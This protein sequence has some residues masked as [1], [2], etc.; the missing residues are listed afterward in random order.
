MQGPVCFQPYLVSLAALM[1]AMMG[2][3]I[4]LAA[5]LAAMKLAATSGRIRSFGQVRQKKSCFQVGFSW[6]VFGK[7]DA[8]DPSGWKVQNDGS[9]SHRVLC[10]CVPLHRQRGYYHCRS[11]CIIKCLPVP[12]SLDDKHSRQQ[13]PEASVAAA[14]K[15]TPRLQLFL[16]KDQETI[17]LVVEP[18]MKLRH[19]VAYVSEDQYLATIGGRLLGLDKTVAELGLLSGGTLQVV[20]RLRVW[21]LVWQRR[22]WSSPHASGKHEAGAPC[23][24]G[25]SRRVRPSWRPL[26][27]DTKLHKKETLECGGGA[28][29][30]LWFVVCGLWFVVCGL[31]FVV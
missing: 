17:L 19:A 23:G 1:A 11:W 14:R 13:F 6:L 31:W 12:M 20:E 15:G 29:C 27:S 4:C 30:G 28:G 24:V 2:A 16:K 25:H 5:L 22:F 9:P 3:A 21:F 8:P 7:G 26:R 10:T 18:G